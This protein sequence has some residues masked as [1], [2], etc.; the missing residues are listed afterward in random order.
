MTP[1]RMAATVLAAA[2]FCGTASVASAEPARDE[3]A[4]ELFERGKQLV[5]QKKYAEACPLLARSRQIDPG[6]GTMLWLADCY[7]KNG[8]LAGAWSEFKAAAEAAARRNDERQLVASRRAT[9]LEERLTRLVIVVPA[10]RMVDGLQIR[11]DGVLV[12]SAELGAPLPI[13]PGIHTISAA[14]P[15]RKPWS[16]TVDLPARSDVIA[17]NVP[18]LELDTTMSTAAPPGVPSSST[19]ASA[20]RGAEREHVPASPQEASPGAAG[21][22]SWM[23]VSGISAAVVGVGLIGAGAYFG[24]DAKS[25]YDASNAGG[26]CI[27]D[28]C[29]PAGRALRRD[30][31]SAATLSTIMFGAGAAA[32]TAGVVLFIL[33]PSRAAR[34]VTP[35]KRSAWTVVPS[36][37]A[38]AAGLSLTHRW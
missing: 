11:R 13:G 38:R 37:G 16:A 10:E 26:H 2:A 25:T 5:L 30:A 15:G 19:P 20:V 31:T 21:S 8:Q 12:S 9:S 32:A 27:D 24:L 34:P 4:E 33:A 17:V 22:S 6:I 7:E 28:A 18:L 29:D 23:R 35:E 3:S 14:A 1:R 36:G